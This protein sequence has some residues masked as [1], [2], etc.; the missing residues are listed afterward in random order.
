MLILSTATTGSRDEEKIILPVLDNFDSYF[1]NIMKE[2]DYGGE[3]DD[4]IIH[5]FSVFEDESENISWGMPSN[6][7]QRRKNYYGEKNGLNQ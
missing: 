4:C 5:V 6:R 1:L 2:A 7:I 3:I